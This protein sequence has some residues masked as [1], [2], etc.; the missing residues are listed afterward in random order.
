MRIIGGD[1]ETPLS[2]VRPCGMEVLPNE[3]L[4]MSKNLRLIIG[5]LLKDK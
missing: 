2:A 5:Y 1:E 4:D 3:T